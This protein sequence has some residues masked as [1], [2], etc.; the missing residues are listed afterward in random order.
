M[1]ENKIQAKILKEL[2]K[3]GIYA[4]KNITT[5]KKGIPDIICCVHGKYL[6][7]EIKQPGGKP[8][9]LQLYN[10]KQIR[11][12]G[13]MAQVVYSWNDVEEILRSM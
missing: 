12:S 3:A 4:H 1:L 2:K 13:G 9:E 5:N 6:A 8:T 10:I 11:E 7:L